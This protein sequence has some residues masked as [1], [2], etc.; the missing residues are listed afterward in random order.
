MKKY[1][2]ILVFM[3]CGLAFAQVDP[4]QGAAIAKPVIEMLLGILPAGV[5]SALVIIGGLRVVFKPLMALFE[6][7]SIATPSKK[8]DELYK[9]VVEGNTYKTIRF[10]FDYIASIKLPA[11][12]K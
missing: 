8:D 10:I 6:A 4:E 11:K 1:L 3:I 2:A 5:V 12:K 7:I 9:K